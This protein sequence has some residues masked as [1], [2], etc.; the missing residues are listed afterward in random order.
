MSERVDVA[1][2][3]PCFNASAV[4]GRA[5]ASVAA[6][7]VPAR[8]VVVVDDGSDDVARTASLVAGLV[9]ALPV[10]LIRL[11]ANVGAAAARN[12]GVAAAS[13][14]YV[15]FLDADDVWHPRKLEIQGGFMARDRLVISGHGYAPLLGPGEVP[16]P[17][18]ALPS[19]R[20]VGLWA[21]TVR[22]PY[23]TPTVMARRD[24]LV[25]FDEG[26]R[27]ND[28]F[29]AWV[30]TWV[31]SAGRAAYVDAV[32]AGGFKHTLGEAGLSAAVGEMHRSRLVAI[33]SLRE[34]PPSFRAAAIVI[35]QLKYPLRL[36]RLAAAGASPRSGASP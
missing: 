27:R 13:A 22:N 3:I 11:Q 15:A 7:T 17:V 26:L 29:K 18:P 28:D 8:E 25:G 32:L 36:A 30:Q 10:R 24:G 34:L 14:E 6:Q 20:P 2:I 23:F 5:L 31:Q 9:D 33:R 12:A 21:F 1:A 35:E 16:G 19:V 4:L